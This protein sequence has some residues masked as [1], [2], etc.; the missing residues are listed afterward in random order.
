MK[1]SNSRSGSTQVMKDIKD[2]VT[3]IVVRVIPDRITIPA[4]SSKVMGY[5]TQGDMRRR[6]EGHSVNVTSKH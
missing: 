1:K 4:K 3:W 6:R 2:K 5:M